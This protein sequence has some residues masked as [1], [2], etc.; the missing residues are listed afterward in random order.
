MQAGQHGLAGRDAEG[1][2]NG[3]RATISLCSVRVSLDAAGCFPECRRRRSASLGE[4]AMRRYCVGCARRCRVHA[5][6]NGCRASTIHHQSHDEPFLPRAYARI[7]SKP[8]RCQVAKRDSPM[9]T[10]RREH[11]G[12]PAAARGSSGRVRP[13]R[14]ASGPARLEAP[15]RGGHRQPGPARVAS[16]PA[17]FAALRTQSRCAGSCKR[18]QGR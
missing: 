3:G 6:R 15:D 4:M 5:H 7:V 2:A 10:R 16:V 12:N 14:D 13:V 1:P 11:C 18:C 17:A 9:D 8:E